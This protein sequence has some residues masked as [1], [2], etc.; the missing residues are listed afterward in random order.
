MTAQQA[1]EQLK[2]HFATV[3]RWIRAGKIKAQIKLGQR[4]YLLKAD[5]DDLE[6]KIAG[7]P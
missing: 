1:A 3:Y 2:V 6:K 5:V 4:N 7:Q